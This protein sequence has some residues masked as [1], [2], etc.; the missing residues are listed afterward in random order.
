VK[1]SDLEEQVEK[2]V[3]AKMG[4]VG[5]GGEGG[6][7]KETEEVAERR[8][9]E[10]VVAGFERDTP[11]KVI[12]DE[13]N[14]ILGE[15]QVSATDVFTFGKFASFGVARF[16]DSD[17]KGKFKRWLA[18]NKLPGGRFASD[19]RSKEVRDKQRPMGKAKKAIAEVVGSFDEIEVDYS[20]C[21]DY[22]QNKMVASWDNL[23]H[24]KFENLVLTEVAWNARD[25][26]KSMMEDMERG[27]M[28]L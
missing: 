7:K 10:M 20:K 26:V 1:K 3:E 18:K 19:N 5:H 9:M 11:R 21:R 14:R 4:K 28:D 23:R 16:G 25:R 24:T 27:D 2:V 22:Y 13:V 12:I 8:K 6:V 15:A 17:E